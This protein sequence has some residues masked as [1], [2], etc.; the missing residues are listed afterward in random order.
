MHG[1]ILPFDLFVATRAVASITGRQR[2][3]GMAVR[4]LTLS[5]FFVLGAI[6][7]VLHGL[8]MPGISIE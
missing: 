2:L 7:Y 6:C 3:F 1:L 5:E 4:K 8:A